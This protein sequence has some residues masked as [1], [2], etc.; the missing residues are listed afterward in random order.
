MLKIGSWGFIIR[1]H[2][3]S[4]VMAGV[5]NT[6]LVHDSLMAETYVCKQ[7]IEAAAHLGISRAMLETDSVELKEAT[8]S[9]V[10][11]QAV[12]GILF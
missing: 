5:G 2:E 6:G 11:D 9:S 1:D 7:A 4:V 10:S 8:T 3:G 12:A